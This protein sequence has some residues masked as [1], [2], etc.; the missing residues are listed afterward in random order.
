[1]G[2][3]SPV[4]AA[5]FCVGTGLEFTAGLEQ[6][7]KPKSAARLKGPAIP[8]KMVF[9]TEARAPRNTSA[10]CRRRLPRPTATNGELRVVPLHEI[11]L[12]VKEQSARAEP[13]QKNAWPAGLRRGECGGTP[14]DSG[15][16][17]RRP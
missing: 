16:M 4:G 10:R 17:A 9:C 15:S 2:S 3:G 12:A 5:A 13:I 8:G 11:L 14:L 1:M 6:V 7:P